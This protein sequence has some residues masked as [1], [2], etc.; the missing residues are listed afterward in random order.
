MT[1]SSVSGGSL[2]AAAFP[3][4]P[5]GPGGYT[6]ATCRDLR[7]LVIAV[8]GDSS[9]AWVQRCDDCSRDLLDD[10]HA[11]DLAAAQLGT[12]VAHGVAGHPGHGR[13]YLAGI[14][15]ADAQTSWV[16]LAGLAGH[17]TA[18]PHRDRP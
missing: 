3:P 8:N 12:A 15:F 16:R 14:S 5:S 9:Q 13:P 4:R 11:A 17:P 10:H 2:F 18:E 1:S 7:W 6:C